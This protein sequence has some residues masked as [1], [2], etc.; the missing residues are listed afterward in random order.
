MSGNVIPLKQIEGEEE[1]IEMKERT[2]PQLNY[3][4]K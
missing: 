1:D 3:S 4:S 2:C